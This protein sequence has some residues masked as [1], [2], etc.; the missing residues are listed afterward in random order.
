MRVTALL[1]DRNLTLTIGERDLPDPLVGQALVRVEW[2]G[3]CGSDLHVLR[4][5]DWVT[6]WPATLGH[7]IAGTVEACPGGELASGTLVI[8]DSRVGCGTCP[9]CSR[10]P[11]LCEHL[12]WVGEAVPGGYATHLVIAVSSLV[13]CPSGIEP[14]IAVLAEPLAVA[15][16]AVGHVTVDPGRALIL[17]YGP[18][19]ALFHAELARRF[20]DCE[21][22]VREP[23]PTRR[24]LAGAF[25]ARTEAKTPG[26][27]SWPLVADAAGFA[28]SL[29]RSIG[30]AA[31]RGQIV[32]V[33]LGHTA[34]QVMPAKIVERG[35][36]ISGSNGFDRELPEAV[37]ALAMNPDR[38][39]PLITEALLL[40]EAPA[41]LRE[42]AG[43]HGHDRSP[44]PVLSAGKV[45][46]RP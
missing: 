23:D 22:M 26:T 33:A 11:Q 24:G 14:A 40:G 29:H 19:G 18:V 44:G 2:A 17:G 1:L 5:G 39:R 8:V 15:M 7:E 34:E 20:P 12:A 27:E 36:R 30:L 6:D 42:L 35:L 31:R 46:I 13:P 10:S 9:G 43:I 21:V 41:R 28:G 16:H 38:Y 45:V 25:G 37:A 32:L 4:T 3:I